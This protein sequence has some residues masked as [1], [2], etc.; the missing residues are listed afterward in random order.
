MHKSQRFL[1][2]YSG[3]LTVVFAITV[4]TGATKARKDSF[5]EIDVQRI[6]VVEPD[7]TLR[8]VISDKT[9]FPGIILKGKEYPHPNRRTAGVLFFDDEGT[10]NGGLTFGGRKDKD[11]NISSG[12]HISFDRY[13]QDQV[14]AIDAAENGTERSSAL[15]VTDRPDWPIDDLV[16]LLTRIKDLPS[17][18]QKAELSKFQANHESN[19]PRLY[20]GRSVDRSVSLK[21]KDPQGRDR[22]VIEVAPDGSPSIRMLDQ[23]GKVIGKLPG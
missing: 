10:E 20:L 17:D 6:N 9:R 1:A 19:Q 5:E 12:G 3:I 13:H 16:A 14:F 8:M 7:G 18:Q 23:N 4:L 22:I 2:I 21:L 11:G 15:I